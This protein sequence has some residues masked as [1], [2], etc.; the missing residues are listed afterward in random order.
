MSLTALFLVGPCGRNSIYLST[1]FQDLVTLE[2]NVELDH[3]AGLGQLW[4][5]CYILLLVPHKHTS[6][7][8]IDGL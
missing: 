6:L 8:R 4:I 2:N 7:K 1:M 5:T 3:L